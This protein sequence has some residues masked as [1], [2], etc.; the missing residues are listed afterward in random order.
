M[1]DRNLKIIFGI[2]SALL[3]ISLI[4]KLTTIP[5]GLILSGG[6]L[7]GMF[8]VAILIACFLIAL[9]LKSIIKRYSFL[10]LYLI[11]ISISFIAYHYQLYSPTL[12]IIVPDGYVGQINLVE[13]N[14]DQNIL[15]LDSNGIGYL[16]KW[17]FNKLYLPPEVYTTSGKNIINL[18]V[19]FN[20]SV[21][22]GV[23]KFC[24]VNGKVI[25]SKSFDIAIDSTYTAKHFYSKGFSQFVDTRKVYSK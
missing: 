16:N 5:G 9:L 23:S 14:V 2:I 7:G 3:L 20:P 10:T 6:F 11:L 19:G 12:K 1:R 17:T 25:R 13:S 8:I 22:F 4:T 15:R 18:C 24:C 21:F